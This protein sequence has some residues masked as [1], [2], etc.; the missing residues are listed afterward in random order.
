M[1]EEPRGFALEALD[2]AGAL[3]LDGGQAFIF[4]G[5]KPRAGDILAAR[6]RVDDIRENQGPRGGR[7]TFYRIERVFRDAKADEPKRTLHSISV[8][9]EDTPQETGATSTAFMGYNE[10]NKE[11]MAIARRVPSGLKPGGTPGPITMPPHMLRA[12]V[13]YRITTGSYGVDTVTVLQRKPRACRPGSLSACITRGYSAA[14]WSPGSVS[15]RSADSGSGS[16]M[17]HGPA[18]S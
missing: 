10:E 14:T 11:S 6:T 8:V 1:P 18:T 4:H 16:S 5:P 9:P 2:M 3:S 13:R 12:C 17:C 7:L 15:S